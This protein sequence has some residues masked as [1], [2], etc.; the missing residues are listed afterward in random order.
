MQK[1]KIIFYIDSR[2]VAP[3]YEYIRDLGLKKGKDSSVKYNKINEYISVLAELGLAAGEPFI[4]HIEGDIW[5]LRPLTDRI[6]F[7]AWTGNRFIIF[8][9]FIKKT[10]TTPRREIDTAKRRLAEARK[11]IEIYE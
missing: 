2:G 5:E 11:E 6:F 4:K 7:A 8:H 10:R 9:H 3:V 1:D